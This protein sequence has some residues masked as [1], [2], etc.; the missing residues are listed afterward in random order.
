ML[1]HII[2]ASNAQFKENGIR[3]RPFGFNT[4]PFIHNDLPT[5]II[6]EQLD[7]LV[8]RKCTLMRLFAFNKT[9]PSTNT[10]GN[11][12]YRSGSQILRVEATY[13]ALDRILA[14]GRRKGVRFILSLVDNNSDGKEDYQ[15]DSDAIYGTSYG[16]TDGWYFFD[17]ANIRNWYKADIDYL[18]ARTNTVDG[19]PYI[20]HPA[21][22][23]LEL[24]NEL[25]YDKGSDPNIN[26][27]NSYNL[28]QL[29]ASGGWA[30]VMSTYIKTKFPRHMVGYGD[31]AHFWQY[32]N[33]GADEDALYNGSFYGVDFGITGALPNIDYVDFHMYPF[34]DSPDFT[35]RKYGIKLGYPITNKRGGL[36]AQIDELI[37]IAKITLGKPI[38][39]G[40][41]GNHKNNEVR[42][43][44]PSYS[45]DVFVDK[46]LND[47]IGRGGDAVVFWHGATER[48]FKSPLDDSNYNF[49]FGGVH[50][51]V[52]ANG[53][54]ND[55]DTR[56]LDVITKYASI[57]NNKR[58][59]SESLD[60]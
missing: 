14:A 41:V 29:G 26:T 17:D 57:A 60:N 27:I 32:S 52:Y 7:Y 49:K 59:P 18:A 53:N 8:A 10:V 1:Q 24:G 33:S 2:T 30:D 56:A 58:K 51:G 22:F 6:E 21:I 15:R 43:Q 55:D 3:I 31:L 9:S 35:T 20:Y 48:A 54:D 36:V 37:K 45:R 23:S 28:A 42:E 39:I 19:I 13:K 47:F 16:V 25:R 40:E 4:Y 34:A 46:Y 5:E 38:L 50:T 12:R 44:Y 11:F